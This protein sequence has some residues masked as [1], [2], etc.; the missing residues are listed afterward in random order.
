M[1]YYRSV[2]NKIFSKSLDSYDLITTIQRGELEDLY[3]VSRY[4]SFNSPIYNII[5]DKYVLFSTCFNIKSISSQAEAINHYWNI[6]KDKCFVNYSFADAVR[7]IKKSFFIYGDS[8]VVNIS[9]TPLPQYFILDPIRVATPKVKDKELQNRILFG[10]EYDTDYTEIKAVY[11]IKDFPERNFQKYYISSAVFD[12]EKFNRVTPSKILH[13]HNLL[14]PEQVRGV[15]VLSTM[16]EVLARLE[17]LFKI[18]MDYFETVNSLILSLKT[19]RALKSLESLKK[20][21]FNVQESQEQL[22]T[23]P[24]VNINSPSAIIGSEYAQLIADNRNAT[25]NLSVINH[26]LSLLCAYV[27]I[28]IF[29]VNNDYASVNY[30]SAKIGI[31]NTID[32][33]KRVIIKDV[34]DIYKKMFIAFVDSLIVN[35]LIKD[36][37]NREIYNFRVEFD[38]LDYFDTKLV[39]ELFGVETLDATK[40]GLYK[41]FVFDNNNE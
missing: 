13:T 1:K 31:Q 39:S 20:Y 19:D 33:F 23:L 41:D 26:Y 37:E 38:M 12:V 25:S 9:N 2:I 28:P 27:G 11:F 32:T 7:L 10:F 8:F 24:L 3:A 34:S 35:G 16:F 14:Y 36:T 5:L 21:S 40:L 15:P 22:N 4:Y 6:H 18:N 29:Y 17:R 30:S